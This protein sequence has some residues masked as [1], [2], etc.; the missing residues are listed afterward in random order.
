MGDCKSAA[1]NGANVILHIKVRGGK[2]CCCLA[3][4]L[5][6]TS[7]FKCDISSDEQIDTLLDNLKRITE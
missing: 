4:S 2:G 5:G 6:S 3:E 1:E 7:I